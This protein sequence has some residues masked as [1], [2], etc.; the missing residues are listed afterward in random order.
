MLTLVIFSI[1]FLGM[2]H[3][4]EVERLEK[5]FS[6]AVL[7]TSEIIRSYYSIVKE[8]S[9]SS[10]NAIIPFLNQKA[11]HL[12]SPKV[13]DFLKENRLEAYGYLLVA[14]NL[15]DLKDVEDD[16]LNGDVLMN[17]TPPLSLIHI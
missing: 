2:D 3:R 14:N 12:L 16:L 6:N 17:N 8:G 10:F 11:V 9:S 7:D 15:L 5:L 1:S 4:G 13:M